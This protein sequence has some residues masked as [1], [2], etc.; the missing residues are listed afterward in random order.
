MAGSRVGR[1]PVQA[2]QCAPLLNTIEIKII[3]AFA[4]PPVLTQ[5]RAPCARGTSL[6][7]RSPLPLPLTRGP[8]PSP[9]SPRIRGELKLGKDRYKGEEDTDFRIEKDVPTANRFVPL[10]HKGDDVKIV[11]YEQ[12]ID[13]FC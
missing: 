9:L 2:T 3:I 12:A 13:P 5:Q 10:E 6:R 1:L 4:N 11:D 8:S 7:G